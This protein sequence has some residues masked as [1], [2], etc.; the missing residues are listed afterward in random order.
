MSRVFFLGTAVC[1][2][3]RLLL[4]VVFYGLRVNT[5]AIPYPYPYAYDT[6]SMI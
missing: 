3:S 2:L 4:L 5:R 1:W 6:L